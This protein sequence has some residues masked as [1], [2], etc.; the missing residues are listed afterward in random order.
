MEIRILLNGLDSRL[1]KIEE[2]I[3]EPECCREVKRWKIKRGQIQWDIK[4][5]NIE[6]FLKTYLLYFEISEYI[7]L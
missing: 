3:S 6:Q 5:V 7:E 1:T 2:R 4:G